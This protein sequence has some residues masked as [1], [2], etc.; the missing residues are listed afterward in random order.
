MLILPQT[1]Q[2]QI[3]AVATETKQQSPQTIDN[4]P[5]QPI[6]QEVTTE[7]KQENIKPQITKP[8]TKKQVIKKPIKKSPT[9]AKPKQTNTNSGIINQVTTQKPQKTLI[10]KL[11][12]WFKGN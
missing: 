4:T 2:P 12:S 5:T 6:K 7:T 10:Q 1:N 9:V 11:K 8:N 3:N